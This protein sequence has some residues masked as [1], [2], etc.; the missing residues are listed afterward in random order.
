M[1]KEASLKIL[2][3]IKKILSSSKECAENKGILNCYERDIDFIKNS[4][5]RL[6]ADNK[7]DIQQ[8]LEQMRNFSQ[9]FG[10]YCSN[11]SL[12]DKMLDNLF[13]ELQNSLLE[14][15]QKISFCQKTS[16]TNM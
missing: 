2:N 4:E 1:S 10:S 13:N 9:S 3:N 11:L 15:T 7:D 6:N 5:A 12:L 8:V 16:I 14:H